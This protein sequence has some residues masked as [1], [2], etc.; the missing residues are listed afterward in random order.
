MSPTLDYNARISLRRMRAR[1][2]LP[3]APEALRL[4]RASGGPNRPDAFHMLAGCTFKDWKLN[5]I[6]TLR[7]RWNVGA[8]TAGRVYVDFSTTPR[9]GWNSKIEPAAAGCQ[10]SRRSPGLRID[11]ADLRVVASRTTLKNLDSTLAAGQ[12]DAGLN[13]IHEQVA[14]F[15]AGLDSASGAS[16]HEVKPSEASRLAE[17]HDEESGIFVQRES[18]RVAAVARTPT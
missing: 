12:I 2:D 11:G 15:G 13:A 16:S 5:K 3:T 10:Q 18:G 7:A 9:G 6:G 1:P 4:R 8:S 17:R 14:R